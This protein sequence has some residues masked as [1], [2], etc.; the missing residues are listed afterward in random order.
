MAEQGLADEVIS[1]MYESSGQLK[2]EFEN[3][4]RL[5]AYYAASG[6]DSGKT[7]DP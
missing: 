1:S 5:L 6:Q 3:D 2:P 7:S 4:P